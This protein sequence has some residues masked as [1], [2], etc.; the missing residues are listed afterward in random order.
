MTKATLAQPSVWT[1]GSSPE[2][3]STDSGGAGVTTEAGSTAVVARALSEAT[4]KSQGKRTVSRRDF[5]NFSHGTSF[6][7]WLTSGTPTRSLIWAKTVPQLTG[8]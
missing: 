2:G 8:G 6:L 3:A 4:A 7:V 5:P 1:V